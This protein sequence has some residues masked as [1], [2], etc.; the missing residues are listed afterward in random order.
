VENSVLKVVNGNAASAAVAG[1]A[2]V[3]EAKRFRLLD[4]SELRALPGPKWLVD[5][6]I[7]ESGFVELHGPPGTYKSFLMVDLAMSVATGREWAGRVVK[8]GPVVY[9]AAEGA[10]G[11]RPRTEAWRV[12]TGVDETAP[13]YF[14]TE[15]VQLLNSNEL[16]DF[17]SSIRERVPQPALIVLDTLSR[18]FVGEDENSAKSMSLLIAAV[19]RLRH[20]TGATV[21]LVHH[22]NKTGKAERGSIA[23]RGAV[24]MLMSLTR[25]QDSVTLRCLKMKDGPEFNPM[26]FRF[27]GD[28]ESGVLVPL[29]EAPTTATASSKLKDRDYNCVAALPESPFTHGE[30][31]RVAKDASIPPGS[32]ERHRVA[33]MEAGLVVTVEPNGLYRRSGEA[34]PEGIRSITPRRG[35]A[36]IPMEHPEPGGQSTKVAA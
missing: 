22:T 26:H 15:A 36:V 19:D 13:I 2:R 10:N 25:T 6:M 35:D 33:V 24:D 23:L 7:P 11:Y 17:L 1:E 8:Q 28:G 16:A 32:F 27:K 9:V 3:T 4:E 12:A 34:A 30:W 5:G 14:L 29:T 18:C 21:L 20:E 31:K